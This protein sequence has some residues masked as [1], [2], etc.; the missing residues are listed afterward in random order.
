MA[1]EWEATC[2]GRDRTSLPSGAPAT[3]GAEPSTAAGGACGPRRRRHYLEAMELEWDWLE[4][5][6]AALSWEKP[7]WL[8]SRLV[9]EPLRKAQ[10]GRG[11]RPERPAPALGPSRPACS[12]PPSAPPSLHR[13]PRELAPAVPEVLGADDLG[14]VHDFALVRGHL[15]RGQHVVHAGQ[16]GGGAGGH[17]VELPLQDVEARP[18]GHVGAL[19][20]VGRLLRSPSR[21]PQ[22]LP[23]PGERPRPPGSAGSRPA[24]MGRAC[25][26]G[27]FP[28]RPLGDTECVCPKDPPQPQEEEGQA[29]RVQALGGSKVMWTRQCSCTHFHDLTSVF[30]VNRKSIP[31]HTSL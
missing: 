28:A 15:Q 13:G 5:V 27:S 1:A 16:V 25:Y 30:C 17:A 24:G 31:N 9:M 22:G 7:L 29:M 11:V 19:E 12:P 23:G 4:E 8:D 20:R 21:R 18:P 14:V 26:S 10:R 3:Q 2:P 6:V